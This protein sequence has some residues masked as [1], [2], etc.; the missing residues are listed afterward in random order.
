VE[1]GNPGCVAAEDSG[2]P[3]LA[4]PWSAPCPPGCRGSSITTGIWLRAS[5]IKLKILN[6]KRM[7]T[8]RRLIFLEFPKASIADLIKRYVMKSCLLVAMFYFLFLKGRHLVTS[9]KLFSAA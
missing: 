2:V 4:E 3:L 1:G 8:A 5:K 6:K 7:A 9:I